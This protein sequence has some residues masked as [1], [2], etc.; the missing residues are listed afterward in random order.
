[1]NEAD[2]VR[3]GQV[4]EVTGVY[5]SHVEERAYFSEIDQLHAGGVHFPFPEVEH[6]VISVV[7]G[8]VRNVAA[9]RF[10]PERSRFQGRAVVPASA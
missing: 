2:A 5:H 4:H 9:F 3:I 1:M 6:F 7:D 8:R 10:D